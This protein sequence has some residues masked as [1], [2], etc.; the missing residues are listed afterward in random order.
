MTPKSTSSGWSRILLVAA[1]LAGIGA[2]GWYLFTRDKAVSGGAPKVAEA[3]PAPPVVEVVKPTPGGIQRVVVQPG[4]VEPFEG[5]DVYAKVS[6][7]LV[8][9]KVDIGSKVKADDILA[10]IAV[11]EF[12]KQVQRDAA[13]LKAANTKVEQMKAHKAAAEA[14]SRAA[15]VSITLAKVLVKAKTAYR[16]FREKQLKR[17]K[18]LV[19][20]EAVDERLRDEQ[21]DFYM[22]ALEAEHAANE[23][24]NTSIEKAAAAKAKI[25]QA[26]ADLDEAIAEV[27]VAEAELAKSQV[28]LG[29]TV[30]RAPYTGVVTKRNFLPGEGG[31]LGDF[32][33]AADQGG[34]TPLLTVE[35]TDLM[36]VVVQVPDRDV[37]YVSTN[38]TASIEIDALPGMVFDKNGKAPLTVSR[39]AKAE[40]PVTRTMRTE[41]DVKNPTGILAHG[42]YGRATLILSQGT[43]NALRIPSSALVGKA[44]GGRGAVRKAEDGR[45]AV[46]VVRDDK[47]H[48]I[49]IRYATDNG[50][51]VEIVSGLTPEDL[52]ITHATGPIEEGTIVVVAH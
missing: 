50:I 34:N 30:I 12:E 20:K 47:V 51:E 46:R 21:E 48:I 14:E 33:K 7:Y 44:E 5:A 42:M 13:R 8:E 15:E 26:Q 38:T 39:W 2:G 11:P 24:V 35:R 25:D 18:E 41:I 22:S 23:Q 40:D 32:I 1:V 19:A 37:P 29:Y 16:Q 4:T 17:V 43:P 27:S 10:R 52:V 9:Q 49:P 3:K 28:L 36:R 6:G 31:R 45:G